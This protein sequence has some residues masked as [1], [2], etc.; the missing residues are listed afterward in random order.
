MKYLRNEPLK[1][2]TSFRIGGPADYFCTPKNIDDLKA[3]ILFAK[4]KALPIALIG[5]G[6]NLLCLDKGFAGLVIKMAGGL[7]E[8]KESEGRLV[9]GGGALLGQLII[10]AA[11]HGLAGLEFLAGIPGTIGGAVVMNAGAW[12]ED[13]SRLIE[14][15]TTLDYK[16]KEKIFSK[17]ALDFSYRHSLLQDKKNIVVSTTFKLKKSNKPAVMA[18]LKEFTSKRKNR[19]PLGIPN[20]GSIFKNPPGTFAGKLLEDAGCKGLRVGDAGVSAKH[21]NFIVNLGDAK[22]SDV[23]KLMTKMENLVYNKFKIKLE[24]EIKIMVKS[25]Q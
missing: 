11:N 9:A 4:E 10:A 22:S 6:T 25:T 18:R 17:D 15:V 7:K 2:H 14:N 13:I 21:A 23:L 12:G 3:A 5:A 20:A 24:P 1:K 8:V 16:G 19:Q